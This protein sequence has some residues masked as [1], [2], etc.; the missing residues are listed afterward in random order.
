[1]VKNTDWVICRELRSMSFGDLLD[2]FDKY[3]L[4]TLAD[5][6]ESGNKYY[7]PDLADNVIK[8]TKVPTNEEHVA[9]IRKHKGLILEEELPVRIDYREDVCYINIA[10]LE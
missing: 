4:N 1:M 5:L 6:A 8:I 2:N 3:I 7:I 9:V 10:C